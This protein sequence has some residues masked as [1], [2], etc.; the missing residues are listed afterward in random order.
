[1]CKF[2]GTGIFEKL[3]YVYCWLKFIPNYFQNIMRLEFDNWISYNLFL[4]LTIFILLVG[5]L[6]KKKVY[7]KL[8][9][10]IFSKQWI[11]YVNEKMHNSS[12]WNN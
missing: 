10:S 8:H 5:V 3:F 12:Q 9:S 1:M 4:Q 7:D 2:S 6:E 11:G